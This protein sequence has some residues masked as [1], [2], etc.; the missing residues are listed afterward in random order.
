MPPEILQAYQDSLIY[1]CL[2]DFAALSAMHGLYGGQDGTRGN[3]WVRT[4]VDFI[5]R[6]L[7]AKLIE[8]VPQQH[9]FRKMSPNKLCK[10][11]IR[12]SPIEGDLGKNDDMWETL[13]FKGT[14]ALE[15][16]VTKYQLLDWK[17]FRSPIHPEFLAELSRLYEQYGVGFEKDQSLH[18]CGGN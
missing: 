10:N 3:E 16:M 2:D 17:Y 5:Y 9:Q 13:F 4:T 15:L 8:V 12:S 1:A 6:N 11:L 7:E 14:A 18:Y